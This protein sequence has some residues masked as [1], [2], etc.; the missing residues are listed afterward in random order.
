[1]SRGS[2]LYYKN[3]Q[4]HRHARKNSSSNIPLN[5]LPENLIQKKVA[6]LYVLRY[7]RE[8]HQFGYF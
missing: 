3:K 6:Q 8:L 2:V 7:S 1:M 4:T 5:Y